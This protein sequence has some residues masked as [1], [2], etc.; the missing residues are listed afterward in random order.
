ML[1]KLFTAVTILSFIAFNASCSKDDDSDKNDNPNSE[2]AE[3]YINLD[4]TGD[5]TASFSSDARSDLSG[6]ENIGYQISISRGNKDIFNNT[7]FQI[8]FTQ[9][10]ENKPPSTFPTGTFDLIPNDSLR[11]DDGNFA[12]IFNN[13]DSET[14]Y[15]YEVSGTLNIT[16]T[17]NEYIEGDFNFIASSFT[18]GEKEVIVNGTFLAHIYWE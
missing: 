16:K 12:V 2:I 15:G 6:S 13:F 5:D 14:D 10:S 8:A 9:L 7:S 11:K 17:T 3:S 1:K 4:V 18:K